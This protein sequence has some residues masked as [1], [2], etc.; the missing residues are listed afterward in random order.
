MLSDKKE[1]KTESK[2]SPEQDESR[3]IAVGRW[4]DEE[5]NLF[6]EAL[7]AFPYRAWKKIATRIQTRTVVQIRTHAQKYYQKLSKKE[8]RLQ[9][10]DEPT[11][12]EDIT[13]RRRGRSSK[14]RAATT[15][16]KRNT[17]KLSR[18][19]VVP[20]KPKQSREKREPDETPVR[21]SKQQQETEECIET[22]EVAEFS[23]PVHESELEYLNMPPMI[24]ELEELNAEEALEWFST[25]E[26]QATTIEDVSDS[27]PEMFFESA[28]PESCFSPLD[29]N[30]NLGDIHNFTTLHD[31]EQQSTAQ[32][33][34]DPEI[35]V[36]HFFQDKHPPL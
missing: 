36:S 31:L 6:L 16:L 15:E 35:F 1:A 29:I 3:K 30:C 33:I 14:K 21:N 26:S 20:T 5:H 27:C 2:A 25:A 13:D 11:A 28:K 4:T 34:L 18:K 10:S 12:E 17:T 7:E 19:S 9:L 22:A 32:D 8:T 24:R 23:S